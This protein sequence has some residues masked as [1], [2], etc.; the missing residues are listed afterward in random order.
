MCY[1]NVL[2]GLTLVLENINLSCLFKSPI[3]LD[4]SKFCDMRDSVDT[5]QLNPVSFT[6]LISSIHPPPTL[7]PTTFG[8]SIRKFSWFYHHILLSQPQAICLCHFLRLE[9][10]SPL[11]HFTWL[12]LF[13]F[14]FTYHLLLKA[15][16]ELQARTAQNSLL[17]SF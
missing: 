13:I 8:Q 15:F 12:N 3:S 14:Q 7:A 11:L 1:W 17:H 10:C 16:S 4:E 9:H 2:I 6:N 5:L